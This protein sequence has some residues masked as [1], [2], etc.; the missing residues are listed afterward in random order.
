[1]AEAACEAS[2]PL[3]LLVPRRALAASGGAHLT[4]ALVE[5][6]AAVSVPGCVQLDHVDDLELIRLGLALG[7]DSVMAD[8]SKASLERNVAFVAAAV[9]IA[10]VYGATV[11]AELGVI[12]GDDDL[13]AS[14]ESGAL[15]DPGDAAAFVAETGADCLAV[16][17]GNVHGEYRE[18]PQLDWARLERLH[19]EVPAPLTLH[20]VSGLA[21]GDICRAVG[22]GI[23]KLNINT[24]LRAAYFAATSETLAEASHALDLLKLHERQRVAVK[25]VAAGR[26]AVLARAATA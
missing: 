1:M 18:P 2:A 12:S 13:L 3:V 11:E 21:D 17:I 25:K 26:L 9:E 16:S 7:A 10:Q 14:A 5:L 22:L 4:R 24:E 6:A 23:R 8:G 20:G 19:A 15:T